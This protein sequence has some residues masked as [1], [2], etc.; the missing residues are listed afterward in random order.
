MPQ[1][2]YYWSVIA[3]LTTWRIT[4][5]LA[6]ED[7]PWRLAARLRSAA[8]QSFWG[9]LLDCFYCLSLWISAPFALFLTDAWPERLILWPA[10][11][12]AAILLERLTIREPA[13]IEYEE[14]EYVLW[15]RTNESRR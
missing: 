7:G 5:L 13:P 1:P 9:N 11:S 8:G 14:D 10:L 3:T 6:R 15:K 2:H 12:A 4:H